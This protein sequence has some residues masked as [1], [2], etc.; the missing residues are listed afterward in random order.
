VPGLT[1]DA[2][3]TRQIQGKSKIALPLTGSFIN[4]GGSFENATYSRH[5]RVVRLQGTVTKAGG[6]GTPASGDVIGNLPEG[7]RPTGVLRFA[8][9][10]G[11]QHGTV[12]VEADGDVIWRAG[13]TAE[14]DT[15]NLSGI[16]F[17]VD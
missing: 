1:G 8:V 2:V 16:E 12:E 14:T 9:D 10:G 5:G 13:G 6:S 15:T 11:S 4:A 17:V 3:R 7:F